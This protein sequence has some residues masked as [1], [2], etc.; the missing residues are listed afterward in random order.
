MNGSLSPPCL[1]IMTPDVSQRLHKLREVF[2]LC[3]LTIQAKVC[4]MNVK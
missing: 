1:I 4:I 2:N 3:E